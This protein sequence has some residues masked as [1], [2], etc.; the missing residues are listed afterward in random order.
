M[1][2]AAPG[3]GHSSSF[4]DLERLETGARETK[5]RREGSAASGPGWPQA[6]APRQLCIFTSSTGRILNRF[7]LSR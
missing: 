1:I 7:E 5:C 2:L 4:T 6:Q 3:F